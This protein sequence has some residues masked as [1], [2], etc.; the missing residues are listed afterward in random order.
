MNYTSSH[1]ANKRI[2]E[3][4]D[5]LAK[6]T[7]QLSKS[8]DALNE[9]LDKIEHDFYSN[10]PY[11]KRVFKHRITGYEYELSHYWS[12]KRVREKVKSDFKEWLAFYIPIVAICMFL[13]GFMV[14][15]ILQ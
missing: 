2:R 3:Q 13:M 4:N 6:D 11:S 14:Y 7:Y 8:I 12:N 15:V 10:K 9:T 1:L 5:K